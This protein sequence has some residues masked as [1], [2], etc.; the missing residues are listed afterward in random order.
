MKMISFLSFSRQPP[1]I[2]LWQLFLW[3][4]SNINIYFFLKTC[5]FIKRRK[6]CKNFNNAY[7]CFFSY[8]LLNRLRL[9][10]LAFYIIY[11]IRGNFI[12]NMFICLFVCHVSFK[13]NYMKITGFQKTKK[14]FKGIFYFFVS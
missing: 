3:I 9:V 6:K 4:I 14:V 8:F 1:P 11:T 2:L 10:S 12:E 5:H 13:T 7:K